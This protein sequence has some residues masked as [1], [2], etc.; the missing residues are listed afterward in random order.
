MA[1][2]VSVNENAD[3]VETLTLG[4][5]CFWS[6][7]AVARRTPGITA[8]V[9]GYAGDHGPPPNYEDYLRYGRNPQKFV[10]AV[11]LTFRPD[12]ISREEVLAFFFESHDPTTP[13][14]SGADRGSIYHSTIFYADDEQRASAEKVMELVRQKLGRDIVT[15]LRP[16]AQFFVADADQQDF[17]NQ[18]RGQ[19]YCRAVI[20]P[21]L[22]SLG[23]DTD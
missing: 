2:A 12:V 17:Y 3:S 6:F 10:E 5:G 7:D 19:P 23:L 4:P 14:Q 15:D 22:R 9:A 16:Y 1:D 18:N 11:Q 13:N 21:K 20:E 8:S